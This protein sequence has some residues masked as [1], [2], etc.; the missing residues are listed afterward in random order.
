VCTRT[1][2]GHRWHQR[3]LDAANRG[4]SDLEDFTFA[5]LQ[6][7][8]HLREWFQKAAKADS[9]ALNTVFNQSRE[10][11]LCRDICNGTKHMT[12]RRAS[13]DADFS[14]CYEY[15]PSQ[16]GKCRLVVIA[17][18]KYDLLELA[19]RCVATLDTFAATQAT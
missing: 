11:Q 18:D 1:T 13:I 4:S 12:L 10:L 14:I 8:Y 7:C 6:N 5:L 17:N 15:E 16:P 3:V 19:S 9:D 2:D